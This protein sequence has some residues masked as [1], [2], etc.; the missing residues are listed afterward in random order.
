M[1]QVKQRPGL[2]PLQAGYAALL[3]LYPKAYRDEY[4]H[5]MQQAFGDLA[6]ATA[7]QEGYSG[8]LMLALRIMADTVISATRERYAAGHLKLSYFLK[9]HF[10]LLM[11]LGAL[12]IALS[13]L[14][15]FQLGIQY[16]YV[17]TY[18]FLQVLYIPGTLLISLGLIGISLVWKGAG[19]LPIGISGGSAVTFTALFM[20]YQ[21]FPS[22]G[23]VGNLWYF[24]LFCLLVYL[25]A[26]FVSGLRILRR[27]C[28]VGPILIFLALGQFLYWWGLGYRR[29]PIGPSWPDIIAFVAIGVGWLAVAFLFKPV[30]HYAEKSVDLF[31]SM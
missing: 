8:L 20:L 18:L 16:T 24:L 1:T 5:W 21:V 25:L 29:I 31:E 19:R 28:R 2:A 26:L 17:S 14:A 30:R 23:E 12:Q 11:L 15:Y 3:Y 22:L 10:R 6:S 27:D 7:A 9:S 4:G 13:G